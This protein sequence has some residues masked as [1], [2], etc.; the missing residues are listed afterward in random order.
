MGIVGESLSLG[1][2]PTSSND[3]WKNWNILHIKS[4]V[5]RED[6]WG[7][8]NSISVKYKGGKVSMV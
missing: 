5:A 2:F 3:D 1:N 7:I 8:G 6:V 4:D